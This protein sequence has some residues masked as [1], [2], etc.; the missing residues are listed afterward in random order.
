MHK[1]LMW[2]KRLIQL[3]HAGS[4]LRIIWITDLQF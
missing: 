3:Y 2:Q 1:V 4:I